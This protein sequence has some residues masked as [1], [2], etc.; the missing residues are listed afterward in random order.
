M[1]VVTGRIG[2]AVAA[3]DVAARSKFASLNGRFNP[4]F[5][6]KVAETPASAN[7]VKTALANIT[8]KSAD[9]AMLQS[10]KQLELI[11]TKGEANVCNGSGCTMAG[12]GQAL[13]VYCVTCKP[14]LV[15]SNTLALNDMMAGLQFQSTDAVASVNVNDPRV[16]SIS[17][18]TPASPPVPA[19]CLAIASQLMPS[20]CVP[21]VPGLP[22]SPN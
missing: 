15:L 18:S 16:G 13:V 6:L 21:P 5:L 19:S 1:H 14:I 4:A 12:A 11:V 17:A 2:Q 10:E 22:V 20:V 8:T 9:Y 3:N 7:L